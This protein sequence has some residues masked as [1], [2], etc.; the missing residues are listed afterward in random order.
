[1]IKNR[2]V[3]S[4]LVADMSIYANDTTSTKRW[5]WMKMAFGENPKRSYGEHDQT[6][7]TRMGTAWLMRDKLKHASDLKQAQD[8]WCRRVQRKASEGSICSSNATCSQDINAWLDE[9]G[10]F[11]TDLSLESLVALLRGDVKLNVHVYE[12]ISIVQIG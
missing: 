9:F 5:R 10:P 1:M 12:V 4:H 3:A 7:S 8:R 11:P 6:P 2:R